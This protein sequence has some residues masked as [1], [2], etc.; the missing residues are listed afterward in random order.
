MLTLRIC[1]DEEL[2]A[3]KRLEDKH[4]Q[5]G[6]T[7]SGGDTMR[8]FVEEDGKPVALMVWG[9]ASYRL[10]ERDEYVG[11]TPSLRAARQKL[12]VANRRFTLLA[13]AGSRPNLAS[14]VLG[15]AVR[16]LPEMWLEQFG[17]MPLLAETFC[18]IEAHAGTCYK[19]A[20]WTPL[21][22]SKGFSRTRRY[23]DWYVPNGRPKTLWIKE[24]RPGALDLMLAPQPPPECAKACDCDAHGILPLALEPSA[25]LHEA[26][27]HVPDPRRGNRHFGIGTMLTLLTMGVMSGAWNLPGVLRFCKRLTMRQRAELGLPRQKGSR[28]YRPIPSYSAFYN[29]LRQLSPDAYGQ[30][31]TAWMSAQAGTLPRQLALD[32]KFLCNALGIVTAWDPEDGRPLGVAFATQKEGDGDNCELRTARKLLSWVP[33]ENATVTADALHCQNETAQDIVARGGE[34]LLQAKGNRKAVREAA[35]RSAAAAEAAGTVKKTTRP[36]AATA[37]SSAGPRTSAPPPATP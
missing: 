21:G 13:E 4:H 17:Y 36:T 33:M 16:K 28:T 12:V 6:R 24:L 5:M 10:K 22:K 8:L 7:H 23:R 3:F 2:E 26:L 18:D 37:A 15:L 9:S 27:S 19:A 1:K 11:W 32:G 29:L 25:T 30:A 20:G 14:Q 35:Q 34:Y 31:L